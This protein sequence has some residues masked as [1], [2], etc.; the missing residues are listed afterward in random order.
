M[1]NGLIDFS[2]STNF[3]DSAGRIFDLRIIWKI[4]RW[5][6]S[7]VF[8]GVQRRLLHKL[9]KDLTACYLGYT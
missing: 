5:Y 1:L 3:L 9:L 4:S 7:V 2:S 8:Y 6:I